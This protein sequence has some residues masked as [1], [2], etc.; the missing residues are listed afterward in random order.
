[1]AKTKASFVCSECGWTTSK[2]VGRCGE[3]Q[4]WGTVIE[5]GGA[6]IARAVAPLTPHTPAQPITDVSSQASIKSPTGVSELDRV[7]GGGIVPGV[8]ILLAGEPGVGKST[9]LLDVAAKAAAEAVNTGKNPVLY[10]TGEESA[11]QVR[12]RAERI[13]AL[14]PHL[15]LTA[16]ADLARV[17]GHVEASQPSLLIVDSVQTIADPDVEGAAGGVAQVRAVTAA[18]VNR[19]KSSDLPIIV[20]GHVTK[21]GSIAGPRVLEHL[22]DVV[23]QFEGDKHSRLRMVRAV[24][25]RY[26]ATD[27]VGC[28]ELIDSGIRGL[29]DPSGL[30]LSARNLTV[31]GTCVTITLE[32]RRPMPVEVQ[33]LRVPAGGPPRRT[34]SGVDSSRVA[35][36][37]A[38]LQSRL[39]IAYDRSDVFVSTVGGAKATEPSV[40]I[41]SAL[42]LASAAADLPLAPG[43]VAIGEVSL[44][45]ELRP[46]VGLQQRLNE[47]QR[48]GFTTALI[49]ASADAIKPAGNLV[50][51]RITD[52]KEAVKSVLP[53]TS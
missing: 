18:L 20:V 2:W 21:E 16:E 13:G 7:L 5:H 9:L 6:S 31:P 29:A 41:A 43:V 11:S 40:D 51:R 48:L 42:A 12:S 46:V 4:Q 14:H 1:M 27:E 10:V 8:V 52:V 24:K 34:T 47:A 19:A 17:L 26:G 3:C 30:F 32:G 38:V 45:G 53:M 49:P 15:L 33:A 25:N 28:F 39:G 35:M 44:T 37:L 36:M 22:V 50:I 23:C